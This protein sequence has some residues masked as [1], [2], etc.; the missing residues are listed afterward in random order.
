M[1]CENTMATLSADF[2]VVCVNSRSYSIKS[3]IKFDISGATNELSLTGNEFCGLVQ[4][5]LVLQ[6]TCNIHLLCLYFTPV[7]RHCKFFAII[8]CC[9][10]AQS[11][12]LLKRGFYR[13][14][15]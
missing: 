6:L 8:Y 14:L 3:L 4:F 7:C 5:W 15:N 9:F 11:F 10:V 1:C 2:S 13:A 12:Y